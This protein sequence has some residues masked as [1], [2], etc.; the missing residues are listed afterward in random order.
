MKVR[1]IISC[2]LTLLGR[3]D[4]ASVLSSGEQ[5]GWTDQETVNTLLYC[6]NAVE[7]ELARNYIPLVRSEK[8]TSKNNKFYFSS[9]WFRPI[10]I[11][12]VFADGK[13]V[14]F[15]VNGDHVYIEANAVDIEYEYAPSRKDIDGGSDYDENVAFG[16]IPFG[17]AEEYSYINGEAEAGEMWKGKYR[18]MIDNIQ[19]TLPECAHIPPRRWV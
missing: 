6:F 18:D 15:T 11:K 7:N 5:V 1:E 4:I 13:S 16:I 14:P 10:K 9:F 2:A 3:S 17:M 19:R 12:K 8:M